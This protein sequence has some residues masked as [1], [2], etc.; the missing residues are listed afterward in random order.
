MLLLQLVEKGVTNSKRHRKRKRKSRNVHDEFFKATFST[1]DSVIALLKLVLSK[2]QLAQLDLDTIKFEN[3]R[4]AKEATA[5]HLEADLVVS[6]RLRCG[7]RISLHFLIEHKSYRAPKLM[8]QLLNYLNRLYVYDNAK[9]VVPIV[10]YHGKQMR[11]PVWRTFQEAQHGELSEDFLAEFG[12][13]LLNFGM[14]FVNLRDKSIANRLSRLPLHV[15]LALEIMANIWNA[16]I[17]SFGKIMVR[18]HKI[19]DQSRLELLECFVTYLTTYN[20][21][22]TISKLL[23]QMKLKFPGEKVMQDLEPKFGIYTREDMIKQHKIMSFDE[24]LQQG[25][26]EGR[27][28]GA[29]NNLREVIGR[30]TQ[31]GMSENDL[32]DLLGLTPERVKELRES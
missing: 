9:V 11:W 21:G 20:S 15:H 6:V 2:R 28:E 17:D 16:D 30:M 10:I 1:V 19:Q 18:S 5:G 29:D 22:I 32:C 12:P 23:G 4:W 14:I 7:K 8:L 27:E 25:R 24:G 3:R 13:L 31:K 26:E